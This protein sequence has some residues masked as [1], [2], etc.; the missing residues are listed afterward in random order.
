MFTVL[1]IALTSVA[2]S[3]QFATPQLQ[4]SERNSEEQVDLSTDG[5]AGGNMEGKE[6]RFGIASSVTWG[7]SQQQLPMVL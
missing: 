4:S 7:Y 3:E 1:V 2:V 5:Q 6:A